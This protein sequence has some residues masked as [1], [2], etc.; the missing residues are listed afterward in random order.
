MPYEE[1][2]RRLRKTRETP[3]VPE[4]SEPTETSEQEE[5]S[6]GS[7]GNLLRIRDVEPTLLEPETMREEESC[8][9]PADMNEHM[10]ET[11]FWDQM[12]MTGECEEE[13]DPPGPL[14]AD[15]GL[16]ELCNEGLPSTLRL[17]CS[18]N[19]EEAKRDLFYSIVRGYWEQFQASGRSPTT[20]FLTARIRATLMGLGGLGK[21]ERG[22]G[23]DRA[24]QLFLALLATR[25]SVFATFPMADTR[26]LFREAVVMHVMNQALQHARRRLVETRANG[27]TR[28]HTLVL[29]HS[30]H[31]AWRFASLLLAMLPGESAVTNLEA[32]EERYAPE[33][34]VER[35]EPV[36][37]VSLLADEV[38]DRYEEVLSDRRHTGRW[39]RLFCGDA[40]D[41]F[42]MGMQI[43]VCEDKGGFSVVLETPPR[44]SDIIIASPLGLRQLCNIDPTTDNTF[45]ARVG[46]GTKLVNDIG[47]FS[48]IH[49]LYL[50]NTEALEMQNW[51]HLESCV[52]ALNRLPRDAGLIKYKDYACDIHTYLPPYTAL[53]QHRVCQVITNGDSFSELLGGLLRAEEKEAK[54]SPEGEPDLKRAIGREGR[55]RH[56]S[57]IPLSEAFDGLT[58]LRNGN[59]SVRLL[60]LPTKFGSQRFDEGEKPGDELLKV[61][62]VLHRHEAG[63][64]Q[65]R[66]TASIDARRLGFRV[67]DHPKLDYLANQA[68]PKLLRDSEED[69]GLLV[70]LPDEFCLVRLE[71]ILRLGGIGSGLKYVFLHDEDDHKAMLRAA[72]KLARGA[73]N[74]VF[75]TERYVFY[76][77]PPFRGLRT[78]LF[79]T[80]PTSG[81]VLADCRRYFGRGGE[82]DDEAPGKSGTCTLVVLYSRETD[83]VRLGNSYP[84]DVCARSL[85]QQTLFLGTREHL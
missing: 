1:L 77:Q 68:L 64:L 46:T 50:D 62:H 24:Y 85:A 12:Q 33:E 44:I 71:R 57:A 14:Y 16:T 58:L 3:E 27:F 26:M 38:P 80:P 37:E 84:P 76:R 49:T 45:Q 73:V 82:K 48:S 21:R 28:T 65:E 30:R 35:Y 7:V 29:T 52:W 41:L 15:Q 70:I 61:R 66:R 2:V 42:H 75:V 43:N 34:S 20:T 4:A 10:F 54:E 51:E 47:L 8:V 36:P 25:V 83:L 63:G 31:Y 78:V 59:G 9:V 40:D 18:S 32:W 55:G 53:R 79:H 69:K 67:E 11:A 17:C 23:D 13:T 22:G 5:S 39:R 72:R 19:L 56:V 81:D 6:E 60:G 74:C